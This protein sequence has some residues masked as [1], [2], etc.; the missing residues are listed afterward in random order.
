MTKAGSRPKLVAVALAGTALLGGGVFAGG[1]LLRPAHGVTQAP[2][3]GAEIR[4]LADQRIASEVAGL[5][6]RQDVE[7]YLERLEARARAAGRVTAA[8]I[9]P[10]LEAPERLR[11]QVPDLELTAMRA[12]FSTRMKRLSREQQSTEEV[13][14]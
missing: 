13:D 10:G 4:A 9:L 12:R 3:D 2:G 11:G 7:A 5:T 14:P 1:H 6:T 8:D